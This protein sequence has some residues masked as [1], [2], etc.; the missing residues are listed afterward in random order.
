MSCR[1]RWITNGQCCHQRRSL[2]NPTSRKITWSTHYS[3][4][5]L[6][7]LVLEI[8]L[9]RS[10]RWIILISYLG[11]AQPPMRR[12]ASPLI[13][14]TGQTEDRFFWSPTTILL[15]ILQKRYT[16]S[17]HAA[18][19][20]GF[21]KWVRFQFPRVS[22]LH[23]K[24]MVSKTSWRSVS[25][26]MYSRLT[27]FGPLNTFRRETGW[28]EGHVVYEMLWQSSLTA[29]MWEEANTQRGR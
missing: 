25:S 24:E 12:D 21:N 16:N 1:P 5:V 26:V 4:F 14:S 2:D 6:R 7:F 19:G 8:V 20:V 18:T 29:F 23:S 28:K 9:E 22:V 10:A 13:L 27:L 3:R 17:L 11:N 15:K